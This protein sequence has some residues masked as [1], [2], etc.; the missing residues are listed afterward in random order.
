MAQARQPLLVGYFGQWSLYDDFWPQKMVASGAAAELD[1]IN[2]AQG[3]VTGG[4]CSVADP[5]SDLTQVFEPQNSV[6]GVGDRPEAPLRGNLN[7]LRKLKHRY[8]KLKALISLEGRASDFAADA[9][10]EVREQFVRSCV[11][12]FVRGHLA[13]GVEAPGLFDGIDLDWEYPQPDESVNFVALLKEFR[14]QMDA[15]RPGLRLSI[16]VGISPRDYLAADLPALARVVDQMG[17]MNYDYSGPWNQRTGLLAPLREPEGS[18]VYTVEASLKAWRDAGVPAAQLLMGLPFYGY[19]WKG[20]GPEGNGLFQPG[21][22]VRGDRPF[23]FFAA[24]LQP[25]ATQPI[26]PLPEAAR[27]AAAPALTGSSPAP[28]VPAGGPVTPPEAVSPKPLLLYRDARSMAPWLYDGD[29]FWTFEDAVS[30]QAKAAFAH[31][32]G[33]GGVMIWELSQD[34]REGTLVHAAH[35]GLRGAAPKSGAG[36]E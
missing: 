7:Q 6:D 29:N 21:K 33:L 4:R 35:A 30:V 28:S 17:V 22:P 15:V 8:P 24:L 19:G 36:T 31:E 25:P 20:V 11:D 12:L 26:K 32:E 27:I 1:Q 2:Y 34:S 9:Q 16:A 18:H 3:F 10:P 13:P 5:L 23:P 14:R